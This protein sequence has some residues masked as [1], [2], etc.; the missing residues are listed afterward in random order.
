M[1]CG[2]IFY[3]T[4]IYKAWT[5]IQDGHA[6]TTPGKAVG[7]L[8]IPFYNFYWVFQALP[9]FADDYNAYLDRAKI[10]A[11]PMGRGLLQALAVLQVISVIPVIGWVTSLAVMPMSWAAAVSFCGAINALP[12]TVASPQPELLQTI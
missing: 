7:F 3:L 4:L 11:P 6:R 5:S 8:F 12:E 2:S 9:G 1:L 10:S